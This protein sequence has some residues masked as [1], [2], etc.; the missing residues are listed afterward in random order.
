MGNT[1]SPTTHSGYGDAVI[2]QTLWFAIRRTK[3]MGGDGMFRGTQSRGVL[4][5]SCPGL[6]P[7]LPCR[8]GRREG[9]DRHEK[10]ERGSLFRRAGDGMVGDLCVDNWLLYAM[11]RPSRSSVPG[12][13]L[14]VDERPL[15]PRRSPRSSPSH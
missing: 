10:P 3:G 8:V 12:G 11:T 15:T 14:Q 2:G 1:D 13:S 4:F 6:R 9:R 7:V 5:S